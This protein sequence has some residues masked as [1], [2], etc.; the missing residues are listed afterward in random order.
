VSHA[1]DGGWRLP[2]LSPWQLF[3][4]VVLAAGIGL[5]TRD[6]LDSEAPVASQAE[7]LGIYPPT[8]PGLLRDQGRAALARDARRRE[9]RFR[10]AAEPGYLFSKTR[11]NA[12]ELPHRSPSDLY[13]LGGQLF[14]YRF[15][16]RDG[17]G[18]RDST[19][20]RTL[21]RVHLGARGGPDAYTCAE[22][23]RRGGPAGAGDSSDNAYLDGDGDR[24]GSAFERNPPP[25]HG[26]GL[27]ELLA[28]E[29]TANLAKH[30]DDAVARA[31]R[32][33]KP[34][35]VELETKGVS[36]GHL[37]ASPAGEL[38]VS[39]VEGVAP[40][41][42]VRPFGYKGHAAS[43]AEVVEDELAI[44]HGM[45][46]DRLVKTGDEARIGSFGPLDPD[47]DGVRNEITNAQLGVLT[48]FVAMQEVPQTE[49]PARSDFMAL[50]PVGE[51]RFRSL[52]CAQCHVPSLP[53]DDTVYRL[54]LPGV[55][56]VEIDL[57]EHGASPRLSVG[58]NG[59]ARVHLF[60]DLKRHV[61]GPNL[62]EP[63]SYRNVPGSMFVT[64]PLWG[65]ARSR[66]YLHDARAQTLD[67]AILMHSGQAQ[68][69]AD[70]YAKLADEDRGPLRIYLMSLTR[71]RRM[72][73][74]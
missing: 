25:L 19:G 12:S 43:I 8:V 3:A 41:L 59:V 74:P 44:H 1:G 42:V 28:R 18:D 7:P 17:L 69:A 9:A 29:M 47:G 51:A 38:D 50:W 46:T 26:A 30:R 22:C 15:T 61:M 27:V 16:R 37:T 55:P 53:L 68:S 72:S 49:L 63:R 66:P 71:A 65:V 4:A 45:Q 40:D 73:S 32:S 6:K 35:E 67:R 11:V 39:G 5:C 13:E 62:R 56:P 23:H 2:S 10:D 14:H 57:A 21:R 48:L 34:A 70:A 31:K 60:S 58:E 20:K 36:F 54:E 24:P 52:G 33:G 64:R